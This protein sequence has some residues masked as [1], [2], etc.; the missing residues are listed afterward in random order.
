MLLIVRPKR[1]I[2]MTAATSDNGSASRVMTAARTVHQE[3]NDHEDDEGRAFDE[4]REQ[5]VQ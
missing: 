4:R 3:H 2:A 5:V 1:S